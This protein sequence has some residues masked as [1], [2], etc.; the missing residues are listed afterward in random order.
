MPQ[1]LA[2]IP[3]H[4][5]FATKGRRPFLDDA[6]LRRELYSYLA[7]VSDR[8]GC[9]LLI[10]GGVSDHVHI[11]GHLG[12]R[13]ALADWVKELKRVSSL[14]IK[15][16]DPALAA[17]TWQGG[18]G[19]FAVSPGRIGQIRDYIANQEHR[20]R[21]VPFQDEY[22]RLLRAHAVRFDEHHLWD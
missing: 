3:I 12:R 4:L 10:V 2:S 18:C 9:P 20:H 17:F 7:V 8:I 16:R 14:W 19:A 21:A 11:L 5:V 13:I 22:R 1:S 15:R 6:G